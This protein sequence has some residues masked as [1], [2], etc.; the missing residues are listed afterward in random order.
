MTRA[1]VTSFA[2]AAL[3]ALACASVMSA[4][5]A[6]PAGRV[7]P[8]LPDRPS[9]S[10]VG[11][12]LVHRCGSIDCHGAKDRNMRLFGLDGRRLDPAHQ[13]DKPDTTDA[14]LDADYQAVIA[15][16]PEVMSEVVQ[17]KGAAAGK[18]TFLRKGRGDE[19]HVGGQRWV[20]GDD[21]DQCVLGWLRGQPNDAACKSANDKP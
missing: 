21:A 11:R 13:P 12:L 16:E 17:T 7:K 5:V 8:A 9:F 10:P 1:R 4:C 6:D 2:V 14:E 15:V 18:L 20:P 19:H 3:A